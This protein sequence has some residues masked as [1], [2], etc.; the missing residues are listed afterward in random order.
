MQKIQDTP[1]VLTMKDADGIRQPLQRHEPAETQETLGAHIAMNGSWVKLKEV[2]MDEAV[3]F[4][5]QLCMHHLD[6]KEA[7]HA[8]T[9]SFVKKLEHPMPTMSSSLKDW[10]DILKPVLDPLFDR[11]GIIRNW[12]SMP[13]FSSAKFHGLN[14]KHPCFWQCILQLEMPVAK[15]K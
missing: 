14:V 1:V 15:G 2:L 8:F 9:M 7:W 5:N 11:L 4:T 13:F 12:T 3:T 10:D 6:C